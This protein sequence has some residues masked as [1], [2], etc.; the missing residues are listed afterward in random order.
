MRSRRDFLT[1]AA[2]ALAVGK[3]LSAFQGASSAKIAKNRRGHVIR[4]RTRL[5]R[6]KYSADFAPLAE[7]GAVQASEGRHAVGHECEQRTILSDEPWSRS[8]RSVHESD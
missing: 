7:G 1:S 8:R 6:K 3:P 2:A 5:L 4:L